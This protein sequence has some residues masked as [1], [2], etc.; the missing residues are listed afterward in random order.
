MKT[1]IIVLALSL[2]TI[3]AFAN[4]DR[5]IIL[6]KEKKQT[7]EKIKHYEYKLFKSTEKNKIVKVNLR[8]QFSEPTNWQR[9]VPKRQYVSYDLSQPASPFVIM[10]IP[11]RKLKIKQ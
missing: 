4:S 7:I 5:T 10:V 2:I 1:N 9:L 6:S 8:Y 11:S 3:A